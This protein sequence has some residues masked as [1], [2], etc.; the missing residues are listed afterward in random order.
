MKMSKKFL[1]FII[2]LIMIIAVC[3]SFAMGAETAEDVANG[4]NLDLMTTESRYAVTKDL[5]FSAVMSMVE[6]E[7]ATLKFT[8]SDSSVVKISGNAGL[9]TRPQSEN[10]EITLTAEVSKNGEIANKNITFT[11]LPLSVYV[12]ESEGFGRPDAVGKDISTIGT[13][14]GKS[15]VTAAEKNYL[16]ASV[17]SHADGYSLDFAKSAYSATIT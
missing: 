13:P 16:S 14:W 15:T 9:V 5:D 6:N 3:P 11:V 8:S 2:S 12:F 10:A 4:I 7:G 17:A 1:S